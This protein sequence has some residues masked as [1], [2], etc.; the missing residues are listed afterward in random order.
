MHAGQTHYNVASPA[1]VGPG[2][3][4]L[5]IVNSRDRV[6]SAGASAVGSSLVGRVPDSSQS[7][8]TVKVGPL[9]RVRSMELVSTEITN[10]RFLIDTTNNKI[11]FTS[12]AGP[13][14]SYTATLEPGH[15]GNADLIDEIDKQMNAALGAA[16]SAIFTITYTA[17]TARLTIARVDGNSFNLLFASGANAAF[18]PTAELGFLPFDT[19][20][21]TAVTGTNSA[22][23]G[24]D[25]YALL[26]LQGLGCVVDS[27]SVTDCFAKIIW[28]SPARYATYNSFASVKHEWDPPLPRI[29]RL[30]VSFRRPNGKPYEFNGIDHSFS[31]LVA[32]D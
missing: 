23:F 3:R 17:A 22:N 11:D 5:V 21:L 10:S 20:S 8:Y 27:G 2:A 32:C 31:L 7:A 26:C 15:Y 25:D 1:S 30:L 29:D 12:S 19:G 13:A 4:K 6:A 28:S 24:G 18:A 9:F 16:P 14:G